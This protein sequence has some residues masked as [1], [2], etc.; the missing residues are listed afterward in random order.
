MLNRAGLIS[1]IDV[2]I[3]NGNNSANGVLILKLC[4]AKECVSASRNLTESID[5]SFLHFKLDQPMLIE[6]PERMQYEFQLREGTHPMAL[7]T[8]TESPS[9]SVTLIAEGQ[10]M[11]SVSHFRIRYL[12]EKN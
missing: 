1:G 7:W 3:G 6:R 12:P 4:N 9:K 5:N 8:Y 10:N 2:F 11:A